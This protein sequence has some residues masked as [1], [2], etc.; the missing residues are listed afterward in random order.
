MTVSQAQFQQLRW[1][2][3]DWKGSGGGVGDFYERY[4]W[5]DD[6][7]IRTFDIDGAAASAAVKDSGEITLRA[8][9][10]RS[11][12]PAKPW[13]VVELDS[14][15]AKF[16]AERNAANGFEWRHTGPGAWTARILW[17]SAGVA[18]ERTYEMRALSR[19]ASTP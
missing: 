19:P 13:V 16:V 2:E 9:V 12:T 7:T 14:T 6:S 17:D 5:V 18:R 8:S 1:L 4:K 11:G 10:V 3:G 15:R